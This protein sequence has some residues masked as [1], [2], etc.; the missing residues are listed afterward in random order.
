MASRARRDIRRN[1]LVILI[2]LL[3]LSGLIAFVGVVQGGSVPVLMPEERAR[4]V[5]RR[6]DA[7]GN[8]LPDLLDACKALEGFGPVPACEDLL[9]SG[10]ITMPNMTHPQNP[11]ETSASLARY[12]L[13]GSFCP[14]D[15]PR[16]KEYMDKTETV[17]P[18]VEK[19][20]AKPFLLHSRISIGEDPRKPA[21]LAPVENLVRHL[22]ALARYQS[23]V[24]GNTAKAVNRLQIA[25]AVC[26]GLEESGSFDL[27]VGDDPHQNARREGFFKFGLGTGAECPWTSIPVVAKYAADRNESLDALLEMTRSA[28]E[29]APDRSS[30]FQA[31]CMMLDDV[32]E[33][34]V[35]TQDM[36]F[37]R[38]IVMAVASRNARGDARILAEHD[39]AMREA[40]NGP[41]DAFRG[42]IREIAG[43][44]S[45]FGPKFMT[46]TMAL[47]NVRSVL[48]GRMLVAGLAVRLEAFRKDHGG[49][50]EKLEELVPQYLPK[51]PPIPLAHTGGGMPGGMGG[52]NAPSGKPPVYEK[53]KEGYVLSES[54]ASNLPDLQR[55][56]YRGDDFSLDM[57]EFP[58]TTVTVGGGLAL[59]PGTTGN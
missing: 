22:C 58:V 7:A 33:G 44:G 38:R 24:A 12:M 15:D 9:K 2:A 40:V 19:A 50:P 13:S 26:R 42:R 35:T 10:K 39:A 36:N 31:Y 1:V 30:L 55:S 29:D 18:A 47:T 46:L 32:L 20:L 53:F 34:R 28:V 37:G 16:F 48:E 49:Y 11:L 27:R 23:M 54:G 14:N 4:F 57:R 45:I 3:A 56:R 59:P 21:P 17:L 25:V 41:L 6:S 52:Q 8:G 43:E 51:I 5:E